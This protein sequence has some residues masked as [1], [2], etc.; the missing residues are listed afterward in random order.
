MRRVSV[1]LVLVAVGCVALIPCRSSAAEPSTE[2]ATSHLRAWGVAMGMT[3]LD[4]GG[5]PDT[6][7]IRDLAMFIEDQGYWEAPVVSDPWGQLYRCRSSR[8][9][10]NIWTVGADGIQGTTDD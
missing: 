1:S 6:E 8:D 3:Q 2:Q 4:H 9:Q 7:D 5:Y 10:F